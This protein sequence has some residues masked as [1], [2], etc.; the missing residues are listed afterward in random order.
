MSDRSQQLIEELR[1]E[2]AV[3]ESRAALS[4]EDILHLSHIKRISFMLWYDP[5]NDTC[6]RWGKEL[7]QHIAPLVEKFTVPNPPYADTVL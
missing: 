3:Q 7:E 2:I 5:D 4:K 1:H 6:A